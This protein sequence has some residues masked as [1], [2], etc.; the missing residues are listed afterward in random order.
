MCLEREEKWRMEFFCY[1]HFW[2]KKNFL[3]HT[4]SR[5]YGAASSSMEPYL[6][7]SV[8]VFCSEASG[9]S[10]PIPRMVSL[11]EALCNF[12]ICCRQ[13]WLVL[14]CQRIRLYSKACNEG[15]DTLILILLKGQFPTLALIVERETRYCPSALSSWCSKR[16]KTPIATLYS[17]LQGFPVSL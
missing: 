16:L 14:C 5:S 2:C 7:N 1:W 11:F 3:S 8:S 10:S 17:K 6:E 4:D 12:S 9:F 13:S 15:W